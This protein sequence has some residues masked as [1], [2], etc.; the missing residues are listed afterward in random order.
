MKCT[1]DNVEKVFRTI[2]DHHA[3]AQTGADFGQFDNESD[4]LTAVE[5]VISMIEEEEIEEDTP[6]GK[7]E[8]IIF[9]NFKATISESDE[10]AFINAIDKVCKNY[11]GGNYYFKWHGEM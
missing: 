3:D 5:R 6:E 1:L 10:Q 9:R 2:N 7:I 11:T 4:L 8:G